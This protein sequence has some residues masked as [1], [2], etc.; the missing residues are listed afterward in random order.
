MHRAITIFALCLFLLSLA[1]FCTFPRIASEQVKG[2][3]IRL[4]ENGD[5]TTQ[6]ENNITITVTESK[7]TASELV[8]NASSEQSNSTNT[9]ADFRNSTAQENTSEDRRLTIENLKEEIDRAK[10][11]LHTKQKR[12]HEIKMK[13]DAAR[14]LSVKA[15]DHLKSLISILNGLQGSLIQSSKAAFET[16]W[17]LQLQ[18]GMYNEAKRKYARLSREL[19][20]TKTDYEKTKN[21]AESAMFSAKIAQKNSADMAQMISNLT[22]Q[23]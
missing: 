5:N 2:E 3:K 12:L 8:A 18:N 11:D 16:D 15:Q 14:D 22:V 19:E 4:T 13:A 23:A 6:S 17:Q 10:E 21:A 9:L 1:I 20:M 7:P